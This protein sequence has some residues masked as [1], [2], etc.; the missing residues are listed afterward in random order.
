M[1][2]QVFGQVDGQDVHEVS[3]ASAG[4]L[5]ISVIGWGAVLRSL[6]VP[7]TGGMREVTLGFETLADYLTLSGHYGAIAGRFA[8]R[9]GGG[10]FSL[11]GHD[12][13]VVRNQGG[14]HALHGG[15]KPHAFGVRSWRVTGSDSDSVTLALHSPDG[16]GG[17]PGALDVTAKYAAKGMVL[18]LEMEARTSAPTIVNLA[19]HSYFNL[20]G[21]GDVLDHAL[22][23]ESD[24]YTPVDGD[25]IPTGEVRLVEST[26][27][28]FRKTRLLRWS[29]TG[30]H[31]GYDHNFAVRGPRG[32][33]RRMA[34][35]TAPA[36]DL[37]MEV[38]STEPAVQLY[39]SRGLNVQLPGLSGATYGN[40]AGLCLEA[41]N[42]PD[43]P[44][45]SHFP[46]ATLRP[47]EVYR[48]RTEWRFAV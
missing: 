30:G 48:Q 23:I 42:F 44:N 32:T 14:K 19:Q 36:G 13:Q 43:A 16:D 28:D 45:R 18:S 29:G 1:A 39:D 37:S 47:G 34:T 17:F 5:S 11:D 22:Q 35:L 6:K 24:F 3:L 26:P 4:G 2:K 40:H 12:Y 31:T 41:Q 21:G 8:N 25:L 33:L 7:V 20:A 9:I 27:F 10:R 38:W 15:G 46:S